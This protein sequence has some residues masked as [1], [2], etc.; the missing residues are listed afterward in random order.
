MGESVYE[1]SK[2]ITEYTGAILNANYITT[3]PNKK[4]QTFFG[5]DDG[6]DLSIL[7]PDSTQLGHEKTQAIAR[8][9]LRIAYDVNERLHSNNATNLLRVQLGDQSFFITNATRTLRNDDKKIFQEG[10]FNLQLWANGFDPDYRYQ[11]QLNFREIEIDG[12]PT[13][14][15][16]LESIQKGFAGECGAR[17]IVKHKKILELDDDSEMLINAE[18]T[19]KKAEEVN[20]FF[21]NREAEMGC[22]M[23]EVMFDLSLALARGINTGVFMATDDAYVST[24]VAY[25]KMG[26][27][28]PYSSNNWVYQKNGLQPPSENS[29]YWINP[30]KD[31]LDEKTSL[32]D[33]LFFYSNTKVEL[34]ERFKDFPRGPSHKVIDTIVSPYEAM[35]HKAFNT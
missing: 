18:N 34:P 20:G 4:V 32:K 1:N 23:K 8:N 25:K 35:V 3:K 14:A 13:L 21:S 22:S 9:S 2:A 28:I 5:I 31:R 26:Q 10:V 19:I 33:A 6:T 24:K 17:A 15:V 12:K 27:N 30:Y 7:V 29:V 11:A 16:I